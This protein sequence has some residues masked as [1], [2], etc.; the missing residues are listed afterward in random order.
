M[1]FTVCFSTEEERRSLF[2]RLHYSRAMEVPPSQPAPATDTI[3]PVVAP[4]T[5]HA[6]LFPSVPSSTANAT[7][8]DVK[9]A[10]SRSKHRSGRPKKEK[11]ERKERGTEPR[12][13][14]PAPN[15]TSPPAA[16]IILSTSPPENHV[17]SDAD[18]GPDTPT[19]RPTSPPVDVIPAHTE[20]I[21]SNNGGHIRATSGG[22]GITG[23]D[24]GSLTAGSPLGSPR[25]G[26][27]IV[28]EV[29][30]SLLLILCCLL[31]VSNIQ[32]EKD[33]SWFPNIPTI[34][35]FESKKEKKKR[36]WKQHKA[37]LLAQSDP[38]VR[39]LLAAS[40]FYLTCLCSFC[41][42]SLTV[43]DRCVC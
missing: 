30:N 25:E 32:V 6:S 29:I 19:S 42:P 9:P 11:K 20:P 28:S 34:S 37:E 24:R 16:P 8:T 1:D 15:A 10:R 23:A 36:L 13:S 2:M 38:G 40:V 31:M 4:T 33:E 5:D 39:P 21:S 14:S 12:S 17:L 26:R 22:P 35:L 43:G 27:H 41:I 18:S 3:Q 7:A